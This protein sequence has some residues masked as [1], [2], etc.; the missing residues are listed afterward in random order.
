MKTIKWEGKGWRRL[1][2]HKKALIIFKPKRPILL[3]LCFRFKKNTF[4]SR[5]W[6][7]SANTKRNLAIIYKTVLVLSVYQN[8]LCMS[9]GSKVVTSN[10]GQQSLS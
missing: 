6:L 4:P 1:V 5:K 2:F 7:N 10:N 8:L 9:E 3:N